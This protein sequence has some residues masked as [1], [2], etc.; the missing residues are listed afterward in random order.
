MSNTNNTEHKSSCADKHD[1]YTPASL[2]PFASAKHTTPRRE[3]QAGRRNTRKGQPGHT[4]STLPLRKDEQTVAGARP[5]VG[6]QDT[7]S[8]DH[9]H[10][11][12]PVCSASSHS[13]KAPKWKIYDPLLGNHQIPTVEAPDLMEQIVE[14]ANFLQAIAAVGRKPKKS[15][16]YDHRSVR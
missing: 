13:R 8:S 11:G 12:G 1:E 14:E 10:I 15:P 6:Q 9:L 5:Q 3:V 4:P 2:L 16:G 7:K